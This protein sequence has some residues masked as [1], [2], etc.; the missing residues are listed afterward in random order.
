ME[1]AINKEKKRLYPL[2][3]KVML[4]ISFFYMIGQMTINFN[5]VLYATQ[6]LGFSR[7]GITVIF[8]VFWALGTVYSLLGGYLSGKYGYKQAVILGISLEIV[9]FLLLTVKSTLF[10]YFGLA[11]FAVGAHFAVPA[12]NC[13][14]SQL[15]GPGDTRR[16]SG[17]LLNY[18]ALNIGSL[19]ASIGSGF[20]AQIFGFSYVFLFP[21]IILFLAVGIFIVFNN[22][23]DYHTESLMSDQEKRGFTQKTKD[24]IKMLIVALLSIS[25]FALIIAHAK[26]LNIWIIIVAAMAYVYVLFIS[27]KYYTGAARRKML[28]FV[29][30]C[31]ASIVFW[32]LY[33]LAPT[34]LTL[35]IQ[36]NVDRN[37]LGTLIPTQAYSGLNPIVIIIFGPII[38]W[39]LIKLGNKGKKVS[40]LT[41][42]IIALIMMGLGYLL[43]VPS[44][45]ASH[46]ALVG[47]IWIVFSYLLQSVGEL[48][49]G[50]VAQAMVG[51][52]VPREKEGMMM[53]LTLLNLGC[54]SAIATYFANYA[55]INTN[56]LRL[57]DISFEH[58]F[59]LYGILAVVV[60]I[61]LFA[62]SPL[63]KKMM[64]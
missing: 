35:F 18:V 63:L 62:F 64:K 19:I 7:S 38:S 4:V 26:T 43:L 41:K 10:L 16:H 47:S 8:G 24:F 50:P 25:V 61:L 3:L 15:Y 37:I 30:L 6:E 39:G 54:S 20:L 48:F 22:Y 53:G 51:E 34:A 29:V 42:F 58:A 21:S 56:N 27:F 55:Y 57:S 33:N 32:L 44:I 52:L 12:M 36:H 23:I 45:P 1:A 13:T 28:L 14:I 2:G 60:G 59:A 46:F 40:N 5:L 11:F 17:F 49:I 31:I 9:A